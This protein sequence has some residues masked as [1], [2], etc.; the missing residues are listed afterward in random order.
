M[1]ENVPF[2]FLF[3]FLLAKNVAIRRVTPTTAATMSHTTAGCIAAILVSLNSPLANWVEKAWGRKRQRVNPLLA[4]TMMCRVLI[5]DSLRTGYL[6]TKMK[7]LT[8]FVLQ[9]PSSEVY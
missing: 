1:I 7:N 3:R 5:L 8:I 4:D 9:N 2:F 6:E